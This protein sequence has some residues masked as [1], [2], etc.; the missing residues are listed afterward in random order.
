MT[1]GATLPYTVLFEND[2]S[3]PATEVFVTMPLPAGT[4]PSSIK[5]TGF[6]FGQT[7]VPFDGG[8]SFSRSM[9]GL[10]LAN[11]DNVSATG[12][13]DA[14]THTITWAIEAI[15]PATGD[16]DGSP[17][18]WLPAARQR[19]RRRRGLRQFPGGC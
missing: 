16:V 19:G 1:S 17:H 7:S 12:S 4:D 14:A 10:T 18:R 8:Q 15:N 5:L 13:Y 6:G 11:G 2:G 3:A 9:T